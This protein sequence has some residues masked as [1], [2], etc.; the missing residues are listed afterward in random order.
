MNSGRLLVFFIAAPV[1]AQVWNSTAGGYNTGYGTVYG[2]FGV[3]MATQNM[4]NT[5][6]LNL[7]RATARQAMVNRFGAAAVEKAEREAQ[8][9]Q[10][11]KTLEGVPVS[12]APPAPKN[13]GVFKPS[14][15][16]TVA[17][18][19]AQALGR[20]PEEKAGLVSLIN[21]TKQGFEA[22]PETALWRNNVAGA[23]AFFLV[24]T[25]TIIKGVEP[26]DEQSQALFT[27][28]NQTLDQ[29]PDFARASA[30]DKQQLYDLLIGFTALPLALYTGATEQHDDAQL[31]Q[32]RELAA[33]L[34][35]LVLKVEASQLTLG[36]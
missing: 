13:V 20:T 14:K 4:Y 15:S 9:S 28:I 25:S 18:Q 19:L 29:S 23:L 33:Q 3:A 32:A 35:Q 24:G 1:W 31:Q 10:A 17:K 34:L 27:A 26:T 16:S 36:P 2:S 8:T 22:Q 21:A 30:K 6:Q 5:M 12:P 11:P 7:Q